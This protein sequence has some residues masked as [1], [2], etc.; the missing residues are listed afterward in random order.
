LAEVVSINAQKYLDNL[1]EIAANPP[2]DSPANKKLGPGPTPSPIMT[3]T[4][5]DK[6]RQELAEKYGIKKFG[7]RNQDDQIDGRL[8]RADHLVNLSK[9]TL[10]LAREVLQVPKDHLSMFGDGG[11][12]GGVRIAMRNI[13]STSHK[14]WIIETGAFGHRWA[15]NAKELS[16]NGLKYE[17]ISPDTSNFPDLIT[18][19]ETGKIKPEDDIVL[20]L[21]ETATS[22]SIPQKKLEQIAQLRKNSSGITFLDATSGALTTTIPADISYSTPGQ[23]V[24]QAKPDPVIIVFDPK[25][26]ERI[27]EK[28][29]WGLFVDENLSRKIKGGN[30]EREI[31]NELFEG[32]LIRS[33]SMPDML[34][35]NRS[36]TWLKDN[37]GLDGAIERSQKGR[38]FFE[39]AIK[40][41]LANATDEK[42]AMFG[43]FVKN[44]EERGNFNSVLT[45]EH[46]VY[47]AL[48][49]T[50][51]AEV[52]KTAHSILGK[53]ELL[54]DIKAFP[55]SDG[56]YRLTTISI[57]SP[58]EAQKVVGCLQ[59]ATAKALCEVLTPKKEVNWCERE[60]RR[61]STPLEKGQKQTS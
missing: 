36:L 54:Y 56:F 1:K 60:D 9:G 27:K 15:K 52:L 14:A 13:L 5:E 20:C 7:T 17:V 51:K 23:K 42:P 22:V 11:G 45:I 18:M 47:K 48:G 24:L 37:G 8:N 53:E 2:K 29:P 59:Y 35:L 26:Q 32:T 46:P 61:I 50:E 33:T 58:E 6:F 40:N 10:E 30:G 28:K 44:E 43:F 55:G 4:Q 21:N 49:K 41:N 31:K 39:E 34:E 12:H 16:K 38:L 57:S 25:A 19:I 3:E